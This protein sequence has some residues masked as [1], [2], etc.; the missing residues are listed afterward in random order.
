MVVIT[1]P[2]EANKALICCRCQLQTAQQAL[3]RSLDQH[4][5]VNHEA[6]IP[7]EVSLPPTP[8]FN[9]PQMGLY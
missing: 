9:T 7:I 1:G 3:S 8:L 5:P 4:L 6:H 2:M